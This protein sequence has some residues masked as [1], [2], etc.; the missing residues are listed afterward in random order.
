MLG[1]FEVLMNENFKRIGLKL[2]MKLRVLKKVINIFIENWR[3]FL[4]L[5]HH[6][7]DCL[8]K[9]LNLGKCLGLLKDYLSQCAFVIKY[10]K[11]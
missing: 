11:N 5:W 9:K 4:T 7:E 10:T 6:T 1:I 2:S 3:K 8:K